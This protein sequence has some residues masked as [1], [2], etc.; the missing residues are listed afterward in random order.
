MVEEL[1]GFARSF[2]FESVTVGNVM[3]VVNKLRPAGVDFFDYSC[4]V[5]FKPAGMKGF[6][7]N[8]RFAE[9]EEIVFQFG[10]I[11]AFRPVKRHTEVFR[12]L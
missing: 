5:V 6:Q 4:I 7:N 2:I 10:W 3:N 11:E 12:V 1:H 8:L 9:C